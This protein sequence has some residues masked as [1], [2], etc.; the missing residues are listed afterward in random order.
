MRPIDIENDNI[1]FLMASAQKGLMAF[2]GLSFVVGN[3]SV[4]EASKDYPKRSYYCNLF[5]QYDYFEKNEEMHSTPPVQTI[6][7]TLQALWS[8]RGFI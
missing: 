3:R 4:I 7:A 1:D 5:L 6:Y 2:T 8:F